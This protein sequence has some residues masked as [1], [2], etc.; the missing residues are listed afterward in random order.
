M[1]DAVMAA[2]VIVKILVALA[3]ILIV[4]R[5][6]RHLIV[7]IAIGALVLA[8]WAGY[9]ASDAASIVWG[10]TVS[11]NNIMLV[12]IV[13]QVIWLSSQMSATGVM[14]D[15]VGAVRSRVS[16]R[17]SMAVLPAVIGLLPMPG[18]A[19]FSAPLVDSCDVNGEVPPALK[20]QT[21]HWFRHIWEYWWPLAA[22]VLLAVDIAELEIWQFMALQ[23]PFTLVAVGAGYWFLL[24]RIKQPHSRPT[25][26]RDDASPHFFMLV[27][28]I[29]LVIGT[30]GV[31]KI[32]H[33]GLQARWGDAAPGLNRYLPMAIGLL[34]AM[35]VLQMQRPLGAQKWKE[36]L[37]SRRAFMM[38]AIVVVVRI[39]GAFI[40]GEL[41]NG[42]LLVD[43]M[44]Q[45]MAQWGIPMLAIIM[46]LPFISGLATGLS[47]AFVGASFPIVINLLGTNPASGVLLPT[48]L[49]AYSF[50][51]VGVV[52]SPVHVCLVVASE[53][54][55][56]HLVENLRALLRP[57]AAVMLVA[58]MGYYVV[59]W[60]L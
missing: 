8:V 36:I 28:P 17:A 32:A 7:S 46:A 40:E 22:G 11:L 2:P 44:R 14:E 49:L 9:S 3:V 4:S 13:L 41:P 38:A 54:F 45:E 51:Y 18:G 43:Q 39:Y 21:N 25:M 23:A 15:L 24:R 30:Y 5:F 6:C 31:V 35:S 42:T 33:A 16:Q 34:V 56:T 27:L 50:G 47:V 52:I 10:A 26:A 48:V 55:G 57:A 60:I 37:L 29:V 20:A 53:H 58:F 1:L 59:G 12:I 19:L